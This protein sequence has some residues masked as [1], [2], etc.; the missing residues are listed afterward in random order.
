MKKKIKWKSLRLNY[1][2]EKNSDLYERCKKTKYSSN[3]VEIA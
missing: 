3:L 2:K 1:L